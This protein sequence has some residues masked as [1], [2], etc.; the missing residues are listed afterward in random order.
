MARLAQEWR[1]AEA[2][3]QRWLLGARHLLEGDEELEL[4]AQYDDVLQIV[5]I[6]LWVAGVRVFGIDDWVG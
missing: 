2:P 4:F 1:I 6:E 5:S 3:S